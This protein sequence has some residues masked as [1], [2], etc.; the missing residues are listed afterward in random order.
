MKTA[1]RMWIAGG[2]TLV[3]IGG[4][5]LAGWVLR[6]REASLP[7]LPSATA[8]VPAAWRSFRNG[9]GHVVH[10]GQEGIACNECHDVDHGFAPRG[11]KACSK[12]HAQQARIHHAVD[13][14]IAG[15]AA[16]ADCTSCHNFGPDTEDHEWDCIRCHEAP[17]GRLAAVQFHAQEACSKCHHPHEDPAI[18][19][20]DCRSCHMSSQNHHPM[21][22]SA[23]VNAHPAAG[24]GN[25]QAGSFAD[26]GHATDGNLNCLLCHS[27]HDAAQHAVDRC[28]SCHDKPH[29][30]FP[31]GHETC[32]G[33][34]QPHAFQREQA[35]PCRSCHQDQHVLAET[36]V[37]AHRECTSCHDP[38]EV[39]RVGDETCKGCHSQ[40]SP[41]HPA[42]HGE[43]CIACHAPHPSSRSAGAGQQAQHASSAIAGACTECHTFAA[44][45]HA[46]HAQ[47][48]ECT[49]CHVPHN[50]ANPEPSQVCTE[51]HA[52][53]FT[54]IA[55]NPGHA[56]CLGCHQG[57][58][59]DARLDPRACASCHTD[60]H[61]REQHA[62]CLS[63]H[64]PHSGKPLAQSASC[65]QCHAKEQHT[66]AKVHD[67]CLGCHKPHEGSVPTAQTCQSCHR[68]KAEQNHGSIAA[69]CT[70][71]HDAHGAEG[72]RA[73]PAC[74]T[75]HQPAS[76]PGLHAQPQHQ[77]CTKCHEGAH[78]EGPFSERAT[79][80]GCHKQQRD[81]VPEAQ[82][83]QGCHVFRK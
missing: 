67:D 51:C 8:R 16:I 11:M 30:L 12:C 66:T 40:V 34:H 37:P 70:A 71:C 33:C 63:C 55:Q 6:T 13:D 22:A 54:L 9:P 18:D 42:V 46:A 28:T 78:D 4:A 62:Q 32:T 82:L 45:D 3:V 60:V 83:C 77:Q 41:T 57:H 26:A 53:Q 23:S 73:A 15:G 7:S 38:H 24:A 17:Q 27:A 31:Q 81:H 79:C 35:M 14:D 44:N 25:A 50:F 75:C 43:T 68:D 56:T 76:L 19:P 1:L 49:S 20:L 47:H 61:P 74:T 39:D 80:L 5:A 2:A 48:A 52:K 10:V 36:A 58:P 21:S 29:A 59:H 64:E 69:G 72:V 65:A